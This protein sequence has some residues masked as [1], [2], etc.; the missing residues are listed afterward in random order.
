LDG[1]GSNPGARFFYPFPYKTI[2]FCTLLS[3]GVRLTEDH[4]PLALQIAV[5]VQR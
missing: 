3:L 5:A 1:H 4:V 2:Q